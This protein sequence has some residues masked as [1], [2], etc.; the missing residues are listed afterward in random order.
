MM[1]NENLIP[2]ELS[3]EEQ[4]VVRARIKAV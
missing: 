1:S 3:P 2:V 4:E